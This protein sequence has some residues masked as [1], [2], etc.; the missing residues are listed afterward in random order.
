MRNGRAPIYFLTI[1]YVRICNPNAKRIT[2]S[3]KIIE[4][5]SKDNNKEEDQ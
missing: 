4:S 1:C 2:Y 3:T 5:L